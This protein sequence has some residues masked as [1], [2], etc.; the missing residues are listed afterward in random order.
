MAIADYHASIG[1]WR[2]QLR[3]N[4]RKTRGVIA[5]FFSFISLLVS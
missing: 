4:E 5:L 2:E 3:K 1:D